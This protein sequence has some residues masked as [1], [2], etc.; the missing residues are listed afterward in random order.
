LIMNANKNIRILL[1][2]FLCLTCQIVWCRSQNS[3]AALSI[4]GI[5]QAAPTEAE[6]AA[7]AQEIR[8][9][10]KILSEQDAA[11]PEILQKLEVALEKNRLFYE[12]VGDRQNSRSLL[13]GSGMYKQESEDYAIFL[14]TIKV[15]FANAKSKNDIFSFATASRMVNLLW[16]VVRNNVEWSEYLEDLTADLALDAPQTMVKYL[17]QSAPDEF[18][19][20]MAGLMILCERPDRRAKLDDELIQLDINEDQY[21]HIIEKI[22]SK[23]DVSCSKYKN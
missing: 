10:M 13:F 18:N 7:I 1:V 16:P 6:C 5:Q 20:F 12:G 22:R 17:A 2:V 11:S 9:L 23:L 3:S 21:I 4:E 14:K 15:L 19:S 8:E